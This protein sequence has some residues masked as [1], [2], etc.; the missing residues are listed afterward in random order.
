M[1]AI[2]VIMGIFFYNFVLGK[3]LNILAMKFMIS[4]YLKDEENIQKK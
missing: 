2:V 1:Y 4:Q 3:V